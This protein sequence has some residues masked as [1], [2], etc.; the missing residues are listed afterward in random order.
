MKTLEVQQ[1]SEAWYAARRGMP[2][3]S[4]FDM[5]LTA[6]KGVPSSAQ[7][8]LI[9]ELLAESLTPPE[10][11]VIRH[12][13][14]E[15][16]HGLITEAEARCMY[17]LDFAEAPISEVGFVIHDSGLFGG[18]PDAL[19]G[20]DGGVDLKCPKAS[21]HIGYIRDNVMPL[22]YRMQLEGSM[23]VTGRKW[24]DLF[25]YCRN[26]PPFRFRLH[27]SDFT[28]KLEQELYRFCEKYN[29]ARVQFGLPKLGN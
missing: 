22:D 11:G 28:E 27:R 19:V 12:M 20:E 24:W 3:C 13:T 14:P 26:L 7:S 18:S 4:R 5:I 9:N 10:Q 1:R 23:V 29:T 15:M 16:E 2:T 17:E 6:A 21:T 25:S 8:T